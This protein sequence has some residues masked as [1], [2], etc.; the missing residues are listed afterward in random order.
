MARDDAPIPAVTVVHLDLAGILIDIGDLY[1]QDLAG[2]SV[3]R[4]EVRLVAVD[5]R[6]EAAAIVT[7]VCLRETMDYRKVGLILRN[8]RLPSHL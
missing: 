6:A 4:C 2:A 1:P 3:S 8:S 7:G 5:G